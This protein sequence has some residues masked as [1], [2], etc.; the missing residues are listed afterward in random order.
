MKNEQVYWPNE[1]IIGFN[2]KDFED[3]LEWSF[4]V[5]ASDIFI[6]AGETVGLKIH[7]E[8]VT[9]SKKTIGSTQLSEVL[10]EIYIPAAMSILKDGKELNFKYHIL[11]EDGSSIRFR[12]NATACQ[13][14]IG[15]SNGVAVVIRTI[16]GIVPYY[17]DLGIQKEIMN[18]SNSDV[19]IL[20]ITGP[21]GSGKSTTLAAIMR[22]IITTKRKH[23]ITYESP[24]EYDL[25]SIENKLAKVVQS[26]VPENLQN[27]RLATANSLRRAP[28][29]ILF[30]EGRDAAT[31][32][33]CI[34]EAQTG[35]FVMTTL[36]TNNVALAFS[37]MADEFE[38]FE[39]KGIITKLVDATTGI[40]HQRLYPK[41]GGGR[42]A[43]REY[44]IFTTAIKRHLHIQM[45]AGIDIGV[46]ISK[47]VS[48]HGLSL[49]Q[50]A[51]NKFSLGLIDLDVY[52]QIV[53]EVGSID[54]LNC[55]PEIAENL[56]K[57]K[58]ISQDLYNE[59]VQE[60]EELAP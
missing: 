15:I 47:M 31:I 28:D 27:Y 38:A 55:V 52:A 6:E 25:K 53:T 16:A 14:G 3:L 12:F 49:L 50:D 1:P 39:R 20:F 13:G 60:L 2:K 7:G 11:R 8:I 24:I 18:A 32:G 58:I 40:V 23:I 26:E 44:L 19:G 22:E 30:G 54:D 17:K 29:I 34:L 57:T 33:A 5:G 37:R 59:W 48:E 46:E 35:H 45:A 56:L 42:V 41:L 10:S 21:T 4:D 9:V 36:H 43:I 51:K